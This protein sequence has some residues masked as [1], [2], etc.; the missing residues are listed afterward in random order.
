MTANEII[1]LNLCGSSLCGQW[2]GISALKI[3]R[4]QTVKESKSIRSTFKYG[5]NSNYTF[6]YSIIKQQTIEE[7][8]QSS[9]SSTLGTRRIIIFIYRR[10]TRSWVTDKFL[11]TFGHH[12]RGGDH[13][14]FKTI[15]TA[16]SCEK[17]AL[18][19]NLQIM[20]S[21]FSI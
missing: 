16:Y 2:H 15:V 12:V 11:P 18:V 4:L 13:G 21:N 17:L 3:V 1:E 9:R 8:A 5:K 6:M 7:W 14:N 19:H 10:R 20:Q